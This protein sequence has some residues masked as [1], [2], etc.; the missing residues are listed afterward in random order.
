M[1]P[2]WFKS[3]GYKHLDAAVG[4]TFAKKVSD[5]QFVLKHSWSPL[6]HYFKRSKR[7]K[8]K[9]HITEYKDR[10][11]MYASHRDAC[12]FSKYAHEL[13]A[14]L[15]AYYL[16]TGLA[17]HVVAYRSLGKSNYDF[18]GA[19]RD[20]AIVLAPCV[21]LCFDISGFFDHLDHKLLRS[22]LKRILEV[23]ELSDDW[24]SVF[25]E[26]TRHKWIEREVLKSHPVFGGRMK[27][28]GSA[29]IA[30]IAEI[31]E[32]KIPISENKKGFGI[33]QGTPISS[34]FA[35]LYMLDFD[36]AVADACAKHGALYQRYSDDILIICDERSKKDLIAVLETALAVQK[37]E[38]SVDKTEEVEFRAG[39]DDPFQYLGFYISYKKV[40]LRSASL[41]RQWR[42]LRRGIARAKKVG[43]SEIAKGVATKI[44][45]KKLRRKFSP[46]GVQNFSLYARR[47]ASSLESK[48]IVT[49]IRKFERAA[50]QAIRNL[51]K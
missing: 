20:A 27:R 4:D 15:E 39:G 21:V 50:D 24:Y 36:H 47:A 34:V 37:L 48:Q 33:P 26:V 28:R 49:Q 19:A 8:P 13:N 16:A 11:I 42:K 2:N 23:K 46:I 45:T 10:P 1:A 31:N 38:L 29:P 25:R 9:L 51:N 41:G 35:N 12:I 22:R 17:S 18:A 32:A 3:R 40:Y 14:K 6:I 30:T 43:R 7:Y 44:F 5:P